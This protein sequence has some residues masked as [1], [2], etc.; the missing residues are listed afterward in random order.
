M[1]KMLATVLALV[2]L[3]LVVLGTVYVMRNQGR[4][5]R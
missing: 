2:I 3:V 4:L 1:L 5:G